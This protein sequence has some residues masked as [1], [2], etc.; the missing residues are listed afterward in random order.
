MKKSD[1][2]LRVKNNANTNTNQKDK[3]K[4]DVFDIDRNELEYEIATGFDRGIDYLPIKK[5][6]IDEYHML[7]EKLN[8]IDDNDMTSVVKTVKLKKRIV[9]LLIAMIQLRNASRI[10]E[11]CDAIKYFDTRDGYDDKVIV[12][13]AKSESIKYKNGQK[14]ITKPRYRKMIF[15]IDWLDNFNRDNVRDALHHIPFNRMKKRVLD[16][17]LL[18]HKCNTHSLRYACINY[19]I[20][21]MKRPLNDVA[22]FVGHV[23]LS[24]LTKYTQQKNCEK[25][26][27]LDM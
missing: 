20:Y 13:I 22:K 21:D 3:N 18:N 26:F 7:I 23:D 11:A 14:I 27:E 25:I 1:L 5:K 15:P 24:M 2:G 16:Y 19:L 10:S 12:K 9:Y 4:D 17:L 8:N 6:F